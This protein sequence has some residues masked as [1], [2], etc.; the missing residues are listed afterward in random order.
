M[1]TFQFIRRVYL[2]ISENGWQLF[3]RCASLHL[4]SKVSELTSSPSTISLVTI[5]TL[6]VVVVVV[7]DEEEE[8]LLNNTKPDICHFKI[9][10]HCKY[11]FF[12][13]MDLLT[14]LS[15]PSSSLLYSSISISSLVLVS[16]RIWYSCLWRSRSALRLASWSSREETCLW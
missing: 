9:E 12:S 13:N 1:H 2:S 3:H 10:S 4:D 6:R 11:S 8:A 15:S 7:V 5:T 14:H 16:S